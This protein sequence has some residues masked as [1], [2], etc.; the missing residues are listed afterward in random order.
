MYPMRH[1]LTGLSENTK[2]RKA[3]HVHMAIIITMYLSKYADEIFR[4]LLIR[5]AIII[6]NS[7]CI[8]QNPKSIPHLGSKA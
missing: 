1:L 6:M 4:H 5:T 2:K 7:A 3:M 8:K